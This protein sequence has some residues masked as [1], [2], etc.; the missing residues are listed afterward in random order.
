MLGAP[1]L[2]P[3]MRGVGWGGTA[4]RA[5]LLTG[6]RRSALEDRGLGVPP[7][8]L[9][10]PEPR[11]E[12]GYTLI[13]GKDQPLSGDPVVRV[14]S[15][16][17]RLSSTEVKGPFQSQTQSPCQLEGNPIQDSHRTPERLPDS[18]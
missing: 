7:C 5:A 3:G 14:E 11:P 6:P 17:F 18:A 1:C 12:L 13:A 4:S 10:P 15:N 9:S 8:W 16:H 2:E